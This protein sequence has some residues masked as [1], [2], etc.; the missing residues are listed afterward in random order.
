MPLRLGAKTTRTTSRYNEI[1]N[2]YNNTKLSDDKKKK[3]I[4]RAVIAWLHK[5]KGSLNGENLRRLQNL[6]SKYGIKNR[7]AKKQMRK[8]IEA[9]SWAHFL[10]TQSAT[11][12]R[13]WYSNAIATKLAKYN[14]ITENN[15]QRIRN[16][17]ARQGYYKNNATHENRYG[18]I[19]NLL[20]NVRP[21][22]PSPN[23][24]V[25]NDYAKNLANINFRK[26]SRN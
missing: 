4:A 13:N 7:S 9:R 18:K 20:N 17:R 5:H 23:L 25:P 24:M 21:R 8:N 1:T 19:G 6:E 11:T 2:P 3:K 15:I 10:N 22:L 12:V 16:H 26:N 14:N